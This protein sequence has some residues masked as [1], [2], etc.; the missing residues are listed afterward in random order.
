MTVHVQWPKLQQYKRKINITLIGLVNV[1]RAIRL[2]MA[3]LAF[4]SERAVFL[5]L[6]FAR[7]SAGPKV[8]QYCIVFVLVL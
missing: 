7:A 3:G 1:N 6:C 4:A 8:I 2:K 5:L